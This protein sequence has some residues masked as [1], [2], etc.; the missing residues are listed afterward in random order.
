MLK[1][2]PEAIQKVLYDNI[3]RKAM[4]NAMI[5]FLERENKEIAHYLDI[6]VSI[7]EL[8]EICEHYPI[9]VID[10]MFLLIL[11][12]MEQEKINDKQELEL[13]VSSYRMASNYHV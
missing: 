6:T 11:F 13:E 4:R 9:G 10:G 8:C 12:I 3:D 5:T 2:S 7:A 1:I